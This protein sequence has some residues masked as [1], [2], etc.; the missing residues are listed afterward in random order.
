MLMFF[1][2]T[3]AQLAREHFWSVE[4]KS[5]AFVLVSVLAFSS[6]FLGSPLQ[7]YFSTSNA[8]CLESRCLVSELT[9]VLPSHLLLKND[10][11]LS[12]Y[13]E[14]WTLAGS[15][16][17]PSFARKC[18]WSGHQ[19]HEIPPLSVSFSSRKR[20]EKTTMAEATSSAE[21]ARKIKDLL[22]EVPD[23]RADAARLDEL[24][25]IFAKLIQEREFDLAG[26]HKP[27]DTSSSSSA[28]GKWESFL[29]QSHKKMVNQLKNRIVQGKRTAIR[30]LWGVVATSP[31]KSGNGQY[32]MVDVRLVEHWAHAMSQVPVWDQ[33]IHHMVQA[34]FL[35][36]YRDAQYYSMIAIRQVAQAEYKKGTTTENRQLVAER[37][38]QMLMLIPLATSQGDL[39]TDTKAYLFAAPDDAVP[40]EENDDEESSDGGGGDDDDS[41][42][43]E[44]DSS[45]DEEEDRVEPKS[46]RQKQSRP[47]FN[48]EQTRAHARQWSR[49]W[50]AVLRL[51]LADSALKQTL[52]FLPTHVL[53]HVSTPLLFAD[54][55]IQAY[56]HSGVV[57]ILALDGLFVLITQH[58][59]EYPDYYNKLYKLVTPS[60]FYV[61]NRTWF[62]RLLDRSISRNDLLPAQTVAAF[63]KRL[64]RSCMHAPPAGILMALALSSNWLRKHAETAVLVHSATKDAR[65]DPFDPNTDD[66]SASRAIQSSLWELKALSKHYFPA[67][68]TLA[69]AVG[70]PE[71]DNA[72]LLDMEDFYQQS[73]HTLFEQERKRQR[74]SKNTPLTFVPPKA[75]FSNSDVFG[76]ILEVPRTD[77]ASP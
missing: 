4:S 69:A 59:L 61:R 49:A 60:L 36:P 77:E 52:Q 71:Q 76:G 23:D 14:T 57:P 64:L 70:S 13:R 27:S 26:N 15:Y 65:D 56:Q 30:T 6:V 38:V 29:R 46:K 10:G 21:T 62:F 63:L 32:E 74:K 16:N 72:P 53:P 35:Q 24:R 28:R 18:A 54:F 25:R 55:F 68:V 67:V 3:F 45:D 37:L 41:S 40:D 43:D 34:E 20:T 66:P 7:A 73:Y 11:Y 47:R 44:E 12:C 22:K 8:Y 9:S 50:R 39:D 5:S 2:I 75:L 33:S 19:R 58:G 51:E 31:R 42:A 1:V 17:R 48:F